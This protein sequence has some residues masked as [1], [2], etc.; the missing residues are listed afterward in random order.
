MANKKLLAALKEIDTS[1]LSNAI[2]KLKIRNRRYGFSHRGIKCLT[3]ELGV[4]CGY[5]VTARAVT[6]SPD[7]GVRDQNIQKYIDICDSLQK[8]DGPGVVVIQETGPQPEFSV[9]CGEMM[10]TLF[11]KFGAV[12][13]VSSAGVRDLDEVRGLGFR[14][15]APGTAASHANFRIVEIGIPVTIGGMLVRPGDFL[16]GDSNGLIQVPE[17]GMEEL[18][19]LVDGIRDHEKGFLDYL[20]GD[21]VTFEGIMKLM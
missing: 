10:A 9:H 17:R 14:C 1:T 8:L 19:G 4:M 2:E 21:D 20:K 15:F 11:Q 16:H 7:P 12:G 6:M 5:A 13:L 18:P 3:P